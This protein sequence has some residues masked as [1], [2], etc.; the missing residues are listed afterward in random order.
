MAGKEVATRDQDE[1]VAQFMAEFASADSIP[2]LESVDANDVALA[3]IKIDHDAGRFVDSLTGEEY[4][5]IDGVLLGLLKQ[6]VMWADDLE[7]STGPLCKSRDAITGVP[8][9]EFPWDHF[10][11]K[12]GA[13][14]T[15]SETIA[16]DSCP[17]AQWGSHPSKNSPWCALQYTFPVAIGDSET[18]TGL[19]TFQRSAV[20][21][22]KGYIGGF[23]RDRKPLFTHRTKITLEQA[24]KGNSKKYCVPKFVRGD[25]VNDIEALRSWSLQFSNIQRVVQSTDLSSST[26]VVVT[27][28]VIEGETTRETPF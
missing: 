7:N 1:A 6:R 4:P 15:G 2:G 27:D 23:I 22:T 18:V 13:E 10:K 20:S 9:E 28:G 16:C 3:L 25:S 17:L 24:R 26:N 8:R 19:L 12:G 21:A 14:P 5:E 11:A